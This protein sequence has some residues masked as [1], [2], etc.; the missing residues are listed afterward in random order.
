MYNIQYNEVI[1]ET[2]TVATG[3][4]SDSD[5]GSW[6]DGNNYSL[7][8]TLEM[9]EVAGIADE[10]LEV[11]GVAPGKKVEGVIRLLYKDV[12]GM[13]NRICNNDKLDKAKELIDELRVDVVAY[14]EHKMRMGHK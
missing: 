6:E 3:G 7:A 11:H 4:L 5:E 13:S 10:L 9:E 1:N 14:N 12:D 8:V 2:G